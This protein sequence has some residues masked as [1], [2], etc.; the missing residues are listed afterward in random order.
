MRAWAVVG[1]EARPSLELAVSPGQFTELLCPQSAHPLSK[2][3]S[4][5]DTVGQSLKDHGGA[6]NA[7]PPQ[8][9]AA[10]FYKLGFQIRLYF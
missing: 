7:D 6:P 3:V 10:S 4:F 1:T 9:R 8:I 2:T 5:Q